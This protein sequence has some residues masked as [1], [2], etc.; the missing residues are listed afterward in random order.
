MEVYTFTTFKF[1]NLEFTDQNN[2]ILCCW[3]YAIEFIFK[4]FDKAF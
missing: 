1:I 3:G 2:F 4:G